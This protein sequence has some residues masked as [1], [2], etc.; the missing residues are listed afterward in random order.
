MSIKQQL[1]DEYDRLCKSFKQYHPYGST[2]AAE[3]L[4][5][6]PRILPINPDY[7]DMPHCV[8]VHGNQYW[9]R[10]YI[11]DKDLAIYELDT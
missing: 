2:V 7:E 9:L 10:L 3:T 4:V 11:Y 5:D 6:P 8:S 1:Q